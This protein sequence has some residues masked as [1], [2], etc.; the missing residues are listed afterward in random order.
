MFKVGVCMEPS[1]LDVTI[2]GRGSVR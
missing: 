1:N 2:R